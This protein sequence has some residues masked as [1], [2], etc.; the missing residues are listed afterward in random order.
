MSEAPTRDAHSDPLDH[1]DRLCKCVCHNPSRGLVGSHSG[2]CCCGH[3][4]KWY[5]DCPVCTPPVVDPVETGTIELD[6]LALDRYFLGVAHE[7]PAFVRSLVERRAKLYAD[8]NND[9]AGDYVV[10][11]HDSD[12]YWRHTDDNPTHAPCGTLTYGDRSVN[13]ADYPSLADAVRSVV[14]GGRVRR[15]WMDRLLRPRLSRFL[16]HIVKGLA[17]EWGRE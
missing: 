1:F 2:P 9:R 14:E 4:F 5:M 13:I 7:D 8:I 6:P 17:R 11:I 12:F 15:G 3:G 16:G 10:P